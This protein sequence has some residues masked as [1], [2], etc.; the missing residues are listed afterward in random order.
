M[1]YAFQGRRP[2]S[3]LQ[4]MVAHSNDVYED[5]EWYAD[6]AANAHITHDLNNVHNQQPFQNNEAVAVGN[7]SA[8]AIANTGSSTLSSS[9]SSFN[10]HNIL[11]CPDVVANFISIQRFCVDNACYFILIDSHYYVIDLQTHTLLLEGKSEN[12]MYPLRLGKTPHKGSKAFTA[13]IGI[14]TSPL[15]WHFRLGHHSSDI[16]TCVVKENKLHLSS[17]EFFELNKTVCASCQLGKGKKQPFSA[18]TR[19]SISPLQLIH[20]DIWTSPVSSIT[21]FKYFVVF[22]DDYSRYTWIYPLHHKSVTFNTFVNYKTLV[23]N[24]FSTTIKQLQSDG[25]GEYTSLQFQTFL[26]Q[27]GISFRKTFPYTSP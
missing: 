4:A 18:S 25:G 2:P 23:E 27:H 3:Q 22:I 26:T 19:V 17:S 6:S 14:K 5:Q 8:L 11:H 24:Q 10:L 12:D 21:G 13:M 20:T 7:G 1:D 15:V 9:Q 16:V